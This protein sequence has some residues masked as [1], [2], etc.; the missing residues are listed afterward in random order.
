MKTCKVCNKELPIAK[1]GITKRK[2]KSGEV[3]EYVD[4]TC[5]VCR[6]KVHLDKPGKREIHRAGTTRWRKANADQIR[7]QNLR[8]YGLSISEYNQM[9]E[10][11][12]YSCPICGLHESE[13]QQGKAKKYEHALHVDHNHTTG[14]VRGLL[15]INCNNLIGKAK[16]SE[17]ILLSAVEYLKSHY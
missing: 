17:S 14:K 16:E 9:R 13:V 11:Q 2:L 5:M 3:K 7:E 6:R 12:N 4:C 10:R 15:C 8:K 1:F